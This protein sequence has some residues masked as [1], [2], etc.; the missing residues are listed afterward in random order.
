MRGAGIR[1]ASLLRIPGS[2]RRLALAGW[3]LYAI[4]W[5]TPSSDGRQV[6]AVAFVEA[7]KFACSL[8]ATATVCSVLLGL[9][10]SLGWLANFSIFP[11]L[12]TWARVVASAAPWLSFAVVL[13]MLPVR[14]SLPARA[15]F[16][17]YFYPWAAGIALIHIANI[18]ARRRNSLK[19]SLR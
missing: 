11:R 15:A 1:L 10:V 3:L 8:L 7:V 4:S 2:H 16:F 18:D 14:P 19:D 12:P 9:C 13:A 5:V 6:G 17:L